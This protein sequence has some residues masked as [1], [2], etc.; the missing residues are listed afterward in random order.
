M[1]PPPGRYAPAIKI[2]Q[3]CVL[4]AVFLTIAHIFPRLFFP[5]LM[6]A[7]TSPANDLVAEVL[8]RPTTYPLVFS[9]YRTIFMGKGVDIVVR[10]R[11]RASGEILYEDV[12]AV[13]QAQD[14]DAESVDIDWKEN[15]S[16]RFNYDQRK[17]VL[18]F[19][20]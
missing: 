17:A 9:G 15:G 11:G 14:T 3:W 19:R 12:L 10:V 16:V 4:A 20:P 2:A 7:S 8:I 6:M 13:A 1:S 5:R 18:I